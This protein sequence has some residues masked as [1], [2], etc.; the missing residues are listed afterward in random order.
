M[1]T[2]LGTDRL[3]H[4]PVKVN[5]HGQHWSASG[6]VAQLKF[7]ILLLLFFCLF[8]IFEYKHFFTNIKCKCLTVHLLGTESSREHVQE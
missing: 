2:L 7:K 5:P 4:L 3:M 1:D 6:Q 8:A